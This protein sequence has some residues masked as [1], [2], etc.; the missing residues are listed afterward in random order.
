MFRSYA[1]VCANPDCLSDELITD[2]EV[3]IGGACTCDCGAPARRIPNGSPAV[4]IL[5]E[6]HDP[7]SGQTFNSNAQYR[8]FLKYGS[9]KV[10]G[11]GEI[12]GYRSVREYS[13]DE[14]DRQLDVIRARQEVS[15]Q[16]SGLSWAK[17]KAQTSGKT[18]EFWKG[19][20]RG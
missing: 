5:V 11:E 1:I 18:E 19:Q 2:Q 15:A 3:S 20:D 12:V 7:Q 9:P 17:W 16:R 10:N 4:G 6:Y 13:S 8:D 14:I